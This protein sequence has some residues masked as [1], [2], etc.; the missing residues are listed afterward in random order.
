MN[1]VD[2]LDAGI[3]LRL[4]VTLLHF[5]WQGCAV[6]L[7]AFVA[8]WALQRASANARYAVNVVALLLMAVCVPVTFAL[9]HL[10]TLESASRPG[11]N[12]SVVADASRTPL[13]LRLN[14]EAARSH[15]RGVDRAT[16][17]PPELVGV[18]PSPQG[19]QKP[20]EPKNT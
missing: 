16:D 12:G 3:S 15:K 14:E 5:L 7:L 10:P 2:M 13:A 19:L 18:M 4:T 1:P 20:Q 8:G 9:V 17:Q 11:K 6:A